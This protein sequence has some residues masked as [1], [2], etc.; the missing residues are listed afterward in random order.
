MFIMFLRS[1]IPC[2]TLLE[3]PVVISWF[4][5][6]PSLERLSSERP[7]LRCTFRYVKSKKTCYIF[8]KHWDDSHKSWNT[9]SSKRHLWMY[10]LRVL[11]VDSADSRQ[12]CIWCLQVCLFH[13]N[14]QIMSMSQVS[15]LTGSHMSHH[16]VIVSLSPKDTRSA[17][18]SRRLEERAVDSLSDD[19]Y[20]LFAS[21]QKLFVI[22]TFSKHI[23]EQMVSLI[24]W[25]TT[26]AWDEYGHPV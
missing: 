3:S 2:L 9:R 12:W 5:S 25:V 21:L 13:P 18:C 26:P 14:D 16:R 20:L 15:D 8:V 4:H 23:V 1:Q 11:N 19:V 22:I 6:G 7:L 17:A 24:G 10:L